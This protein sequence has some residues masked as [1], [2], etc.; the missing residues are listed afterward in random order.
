VNVSAPLVFDQDVADLRGRADDDVQ[1]PRR[2]AGLGGELREEERRERSLRGRLE[3]HGAA[4]GERWRELVGDEVEREVERADRRDDAD[5]DAERE[6]ELPGA[7]LRG[8]HRHDLAGELPCLD[9]GHRVGRHRPCGLDSG[10]LHRLAGLG[11]DRPRGIVLAITQ[12]VCDAREDLGAPV[13][14]QRVA[15]RRLGGVHRPAGLVAPGL[16]HV[17]DGLA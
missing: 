11:A 13:R 5:R 4:G 9:R 6:C 1:P 7:G 15:R 12:A 2:Q 16:R 14:R 10:G 17:P 8:V 3:H